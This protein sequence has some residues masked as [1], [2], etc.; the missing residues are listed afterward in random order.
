M[1]VYSMLSLPIGAFD[2]SE[3]Q[4]RLALLQGLLGDAS[5]VLPFPIPSFKIGTLDALV[6]QADEL[7]K[8][9]SACQS[10][11]AKV[12]D[13]LKNI[14]DGDEDKIAQQKTVNDKPT[15][16]YISSF[17]WNKARYRADKPISELVDMLQKELATT[18]NDIKA[19]FQQYNSV[20][21]NL[22][23]LQRRQTGNL[24]TK[25][26]APIVDPALLIHESEYLETHLIAVPTVAKKEFLSSY[27]TLAPMVVPRSSTQVAEDDEFTLYAVVT[28][29][30]HSSEFLH[31]CRE[32]KWTPRQ[33]KFSE[34]SREEEEKELERVGREEKKVWGEALRMGRS[35]W[36]ESVMVW[37]HVMTLRVFVE[38]VLRYGLPLDYVS[39]IVRTKAAKT[40][41]K[42]RTVLD[43][44]YS[45]LAGNAMARD[46][47]GKVTKDDAQ[48]TSDMAAAGF[49][50]GEG[51]EY[52]AYVYYE[53][54]FP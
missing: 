10:V 12:A 48:L 13:S 8:L 54:D 32:Q 2:S 33:F 26:L 23:A 11:A 47:K 36:S 3:H 40:T 44:K 17:S 25:S 28:F 20:K 45:Y 5:T 9:D 21:T 1:S 14:L 7:A 46:K 24:S 29:K 34:A 37:M 15:D 42:L 52:T 22:A 35:G 50:S 41:K 49:G 51:N 4:D 27:E 6:Q 43:Q 16:H 19:K 18:D 38:A 39:A 31:K 53:F 30:K